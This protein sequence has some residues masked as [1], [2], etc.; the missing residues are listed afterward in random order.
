MTNYRV[1]LDDVPFPG[2]WAQHG[3]CRSTATEIFFPARGA[4]TEPAKEVCRTC[5]VRDE[6]REYS[7]PL[8]TLKGVW[9]GL[10]EV[11]RRRLRA[12]PTHAQP[13]E[14]QAGRSRRVRRSPLY[15]ALEELAA[16][17]GRWARAVWYPGAHTAG[18]MASRLRR[19][20]VAAPEGAWQFEAGPSE[21]GSGLWACY[22][23]PRPGGGALHCNGELGVPAR[24]IGD[25]LCSPSGCLR[26]SL[27]LEPVPYWA[28][29]VSHLD[30]MPSAT[31]G[32]GG[33]V[34]SSEALERSTGCSSAAV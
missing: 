10:A 31:E 3:A 2:P 32:R 16:S 4:S 33:E 25:K 13:G 34:K 21:G 28:D 24:D 19:G 18:G 29:Q 17:P 20:I 1:P 14:R 6:C 27:D 5:P 7:L 8:R 11:E 30:W 12:T 23:R 22:E 9:G 26:E 15:R